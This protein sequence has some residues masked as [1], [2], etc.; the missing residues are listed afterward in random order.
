MC[1]S[2][3][4]NESVNRSYTSSKYFPGFEALAALTMKISFHMNTGSSCSSYTLLSF[5]KKLHD[6]TFSKTVI[7]ETTARKMYRQA[8]NIC[9]SQ[10][11]CC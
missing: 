6:I 3:F 7:L 5:Y 9:F 2:N 1:F 8:H 11:Y 10:S 4:R